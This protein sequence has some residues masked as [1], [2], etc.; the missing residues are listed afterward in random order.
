QSV[1]LTELGSSCFDQTVENCC[2]T[3]SMFSR[4]TPSAKMLPVLE[5]LGN[6]SAATDGGTEQQVTVTASSRF[7]TPVKQSSSLETMNIN[8]EID[9]Q[10]FLAKVDQTKFV[11]TDDN[12]VDYYVLTKGSD[13]KSTTQRLMPHRYTPTTPIIFQIGDIVEIQTSMTCIPVKGNFMVKLL[14]RSIILL[15][16]SLTM[17]RYHKVS[18]PVPGAHGATLGGNN[19]P[20][21]SHSKPC[22]TSEMVE[23][24]QSIHR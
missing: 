14:L 9:L 21:A 13:E 2:H 4:Y 19:R 8:T 15:D 16:G 10:G 24:A 11:H 1:T 5:F 6:H 12:T 23:T 17:V 20:D 22:S 3:Y 7:F 18:S